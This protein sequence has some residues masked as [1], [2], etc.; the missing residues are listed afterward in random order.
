MIC[1]VLAL[2]SAT[3]QAASYEIHTGRYGVKSLGPFFAQQTARYKPTLDV[4]TSK[5]GRP[6]NVFRVRGGGC[7]AKWKQLGLRI[8]FWSFSVADDCD[9]GLAQSFSIERSRKWVTWRGL[10]I[11]MTETQLLDRHPRA[12]WERAIRG[13]PKGW[14]LKTAYSPYGDG[15]PYPVISA[16][17]RHGDTGRVDSLR[18]WIGSAGE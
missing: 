5:F 2:A 3:A 16:H 13:T 4:A 12:T 8:E 14:W 6:S 18:G 15:S 7:V 10:R 11:T 9:G 1:A 17:L